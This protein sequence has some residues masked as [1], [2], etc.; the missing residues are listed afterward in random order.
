LTIFQHLSGQNSK[1]HSTGRKG[2]KR[3]GDKRKN[4]T[5]TAKK[6]TNDL[7]DLRRDRKQTEFSYG[8][9]QFQE[10]SGKNNKDKHNSYKHR[11]DHR[12]IG[13]KKTMTETGRVAHEQAAP[14]AK[15]ADPGR[16]EKSEIPESEPR[17]WG[18]TAKTG[19]KNLSIWGGKNE[20]I[21][22]SQGM[23]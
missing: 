2:E 9:T 10:F 16:L 5:F 11:R 8:L 21:R 7:L 19:K 23:H 15:K 17:V 20:D 14:L 22:E 18:R 1:G 6:K 13:T 4:R 3:H 12:H